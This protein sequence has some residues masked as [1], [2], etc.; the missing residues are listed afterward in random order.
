MIDGSRIFKHPHRAS[1]PDHVVIILRGLPGPGCSSMIGAMTTVVGTAKAFQRLA[2]YD[3]LNSGINNYHVT[4]WYSSHKDDTE[5][6]PHGMVSNAFLQLVGGHFTRMLFDFVKEMPKRETETRMD[7][8]SLLGPFFFTWVILQLFRIVLTALVYEK[9]QNLRIMM[10]MHGLG[11]GPYLMISYAY[12]L[13]I[14]VVY[15]FCFVVF[16]SAVWLNFYTLNDYSIQFV[17]YF[18]YVNLQ[19]ALAFLMVALFSNVKIAAVVGYHGWP[20][21]GGM[22]RDNTRPRGN[23]YHR[24]PT[25]LLKMAMYHQIED[26][27]GPKVPVPLKSRLFPFDIEEDDVESTNF[28]LGSQDSEMNDLDGKDLGLFD[29]AYFLGDFNLQSVKFAKTTKFEEAT[30]VCTDSIRLSGVLD[31]RLADDDSNHGSR[32][33][34]R[35]K[36]TRL[37]GYTKYVDFVNDRRMAMSSSKVHTSSLYLRNALYS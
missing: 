10:K 19:I 17:L 32:V 18:L 35:H 26:H 28:C 22:E 29:I 1:H 5:N 23:D 25:R 13:V 34:L 12:F 16:G 30:F 7:F 11:D 24:T 36:S 9:Q 20:S 33:Q 8:S 15:M 37:L 6:E 3:F 21:W 4:V 31:S 27:E 14:Y 2:S